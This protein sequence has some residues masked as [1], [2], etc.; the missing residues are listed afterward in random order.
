MALIANKAGS[1]QVAAGEVEPA[2]G[3]EGGGEEIG[4]DVPYEYG[5]FFRMKIVKLIVDGCECREEKDRNGSVEHLILWVVL[6]KIN[7]Y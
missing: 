3:Q 1:E 2:V 5:H 6:K 7:A 4:G